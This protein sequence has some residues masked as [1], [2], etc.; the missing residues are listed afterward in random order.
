MASGADTGEREV[1]LWSI[2]ALILSSDVN[3][4][5]AKLWTENV[6]VSDFGSLALSIMILG[7]SIIPM[8]SSS[9][10][11]RPSQMPLVR[12]AMHSVLHV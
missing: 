1:D 3:T 5:A 12:L 4:G 2:F 7:T 9:W 8:T 6:I 11:N 10:A